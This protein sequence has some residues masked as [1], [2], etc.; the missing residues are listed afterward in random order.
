MFRLRRWQRLKGVRNLL[1]PRHLGL[2]VNLRAGLEVL[3]LAAEEHGARN[4][5][6]GAHDLLVVVDVGRAVGAVVAVHGLAC[7]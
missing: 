4:D 3:A 6:V 1:L 5:G 7:S 2:A